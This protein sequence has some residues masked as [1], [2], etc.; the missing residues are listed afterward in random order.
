[1]N[2]PLFYKLRNEGLISDASLERVE[3]NTTDQLFSVRWELRTLLYLGIILLTWGLGILVYKNIDS[4]GHMAVLFFIAILSSGSYY[5]CYKKKMPFSN[6]KVASPNAAFDY[7]LL[8]GCLTFVIFVGYFQ[9]QYNI[10]G[11]RYGLATFLPMLVLFATAYY[12][13]H[14]GILS[15]AITNMGA[16]LGLTVTPLHLLASNDFSNSRIIF[17]GIAF[18]I[19]LIIAGKISTLRNLKA[20]FC[21][22]YTNFGMH[23]MF[24][25]LLAAMFHFDNIYLLWFLMLTCAAYYFYRTA[26]TM[27]SFYFLLFATLYTY[28]GASYVIIRLLTFFDFEMGAIYL[29]LIYFIASAIFVCIFLIRQNKSLKA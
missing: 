17:T 13:D 23:I 22:S 7:I 6:E 15:M 9:Y 26:M 2:L 1:M 4:I 18:G 24:I 29:G 14:F 20:H 19:M 25:S 8:L 10:F 12:F 11:N 3:S 5:Y 16:W 21:F 28:V 27:R